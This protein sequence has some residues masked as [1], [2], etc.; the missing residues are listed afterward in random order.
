MFNDSGNT[1]FNPRDNVS[2]GI[3]SLDAKILFVSRIFT[4]KKPC[5]SI[6]ERALPRSV[7]PEYIA[8]LSIRIKDKSFD[9][10]EILEE[11]KR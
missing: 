7:V 3:K 6:K 10:F 4:E 8:V 5:K 2:V 11:S 1:M 9:A